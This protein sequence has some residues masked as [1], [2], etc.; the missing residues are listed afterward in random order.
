VTARARRVV[1]VAGTFAAL[2]VA[3]AGGFWWLVDTQRGATWGVERLGA[4]F[5]G[6]LDVLEAR[7]R[8][9]GPL[10]VRHFT[11][12]TEHMEIT[13][14]RVQIDWNLRQLVWRRLDFH[15]IQ[16]DGVRVLM[17]ASGDTPAERD[18]LRGPLP[19]LDLPVA[20]VVRDGVVN[21]LTLAT[22]GN[23]SVLVLDRV[24][25]DARSMRGDSLF[26][27][28]LAV[29]SKPLDLEFSGAALPRGGYPVLLRGSW[30][31]RPEG[32][33]AIQGTGTLAGSLDTLRVRQD[34]SGPFA[35]RVDVRFF[36]PLRNLRYEGEV[37]FSELSPRTTLGSQW[38]AGRFGGRAS[39]S[40][41]L[42]DLRSQGSL[43]G[44]SDAIGPASAD[45][46]VR[47]VDRV[48]NIESLAVR[49][50][51][52]RARLLAR[53]TVVVD[54]IAPRFD[55]QTEW[56]ELGWPLDG[57][58]WV[59][60]ERG[61]GRLA[62]TP[63]DFSIH[64]QALLAGRD[65]PPGTWT[66]D[67]RGGQGRLAIR[68]VV[69]DLLDGRIVGAGSVA[70]NPR[71]SWRLSF[72][73]TGINPG[74]AWPHYAGALTFTGRSEGSTGP[75]GPS[76][77]IL[78]SSL[79]GTLRGQTVSGRGTL[80]AGQGQ[81]SLA[82]A[83]LQWGPNRAE[84]TGGFGR[85]WS[86]DW[87]LDAPQ[88]AAAF[89]Q[90]SGSLRGQ[91]SVRGARGSSRVT[92]TLAGDSLFWGRAHARAIRA[93]ADLDLSPG[94]VI[95]LDVVAS[96]VSAGTRA[97][98]HLILAG[99]GT[100]DQHQLR[101]SLA[102]RA[103]STVVVLAGAFGPDE[104]RGE[105]RSFDLVHPRTS[106]WSLAAPARLTVIG[107][108][109]ALSEFAWQSGTSRIV[110]AADWKR[111]GPWSLDSRLEGVELSL[112]EPMLP[113]RLHL[114]GPLQGHFTAHGTEAGQ[115]FADVDVVPGPGQVLH[116]TGSGQ[117]VAT[118]FEN[119]SL[120]AT[121]D[122]RR[123]QAALATDL[124]GVG[125]VR[126]AFGWPAYAVARGASR[127]PL[128]GRVTLHLRDLGLLQGFTSELDATAGTLDADLGI[129]GTVAEPF[130]QGPLTL[131]NG[132][133]Y[134]PRLGLQL[135]EGS[136]VATGSPGGR[137]AIDGRVRSGPGLLTFTGTAAM[138]RG[139]NPVAKLKLSGDRVQAINT[140]DIKFLAS[141]D[142]DVALDGNRLD[143]TGEVKISD[144]EIDVGEADDRRLVRVSDDVVFTGAD[145][146]AGTP[147][148]LRARV[149]LVL[150][151][152]VVVR[153]F[154]LE[155]RPTGS[156]LATDA[157]GL[158]TLGTGRL[159]IKDGTYNV[160]GQ[161][162][163]VQNGSLIFGGGPIAN[164][165]IRVRASRTAADGVVAG[166]DV[167]GTVIRPDVRV[168]SEPA[169]GQSQAL[170]YI[171]FGKPIERGNL[172]EGQIAST[173]A[174]TLGIP[175][176]NLLAHGLASELGIE[177]ARI[178]VGNSFQSTS[179]SLG[180]HLSP[181]LYI[182]YGMDVFEA[183]SSLRLRYILNRL[184]TI[185]AETARQNR[186]DLLYTLEK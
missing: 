162:L 92:G 45:F 173:M 56:S 3:A 165:A 67:G 149:R 128:D 6:K 151:D 57:A 39:L 178:E 115:L 83:G 177:Q 30:T 113:P 104:W 112:L 64:L 9:R 32:R 143:V 160:Y 133:A 10:E 23:D 2:A 47:R 43:S 34:L 102:G 182:G 65:I 90:A 46:R 74:A 168:F 55:L 95:R 186:V 122:G 49:R 176:T 132:S 58:P 1:W 145:T 68:T 16:A 25:L 86:L 84:A 51:G 44:S 120:R 158:P 142:L 38:P 69:A 97:A 66:L 130:V 174:T 167:R 152:K 52:S 117:W 101:A 4:L 31:F 155:V 88:L 8:L 107:G 179:L 175:G 29:R 40:G 22:L 163:E 100:R 18:S 71:V 42:A 82:D 62:G 134:L 161:D 183:S 105:V 21:H 63:R 94:G 99:S 137:L 139:G 164:P 37:T 109:V 121:A 53:G 20:I 144:G 13:A 73:G 170:S 111:G 19:D 27:N 180:T 54:S 119:A 153:G 17:G 116:S 96:K 127:Q 26:V 72:D 159:D 135:R 75:S 169:M 35:A 125:T 12:R 79:S 126:A 136:V 93:D 41:D 60:S 7:G 166:F 108:R 80:T 172:S 59:S 154:G 150:G 138:A 89:P 77:Q 78:V 185:E 14:D 48:W 141:P 50:P 103:E 184:F 131:K 76:G 157:P 110:L 91:G 85:S 98:E 156:V 11:Y 147:R 181:K 118:P 148:E 124:V 70:W 129:G 24:T 5:P 114:T 15:R 81:Y 123:T 140:S 36:R 146:L 33:P 61:T 28:R 171:L 106:P 87:K